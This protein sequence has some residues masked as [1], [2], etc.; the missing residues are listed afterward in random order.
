MSRENKDANLAITKKREREMG[1]P[2]RELGSSAI[3]PAEEEEPKVTTVSRK[4]GR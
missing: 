3:K 4:K 1:T 2:Q